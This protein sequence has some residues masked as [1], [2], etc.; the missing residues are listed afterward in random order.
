MV[1]HAFDI[2]MNHSVINAEQLQKFGEQLVP[3]GDSGGQ[4]LPRCS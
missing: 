4:F 3:L 1:L 2:V